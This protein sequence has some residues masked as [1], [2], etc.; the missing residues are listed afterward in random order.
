MSEKHLGNGS[1]SKW[2]TE[3]DAV[4]RRM[5][6]EDFSSAQIGRA[7]NF[8]F[9]TSY[10]RNAVIGRCHRLELT[11]KPG[12]P[13]RDPT[14]RVRT[15]PFRA[16]SARTSH[17]LPE[18]ECAEVV[19]LHLALLDLAAGQCRWPFGE[20]PFTFCGCPTFDEASYCPVHAARSV[21]GTA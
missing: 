9:G 6:D 2:T 1:A 7:L 14:P 3:H 21:R 10:S 12:G 13:T 18:M 19:P 5:R 16:P 17:H 11:N 8:E 20:R 4:L 15:T